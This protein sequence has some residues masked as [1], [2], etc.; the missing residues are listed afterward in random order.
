MKL[1]SRISKYFVAYLAWVLFILLFVVVILLGRDVLLGYLRNIWAQQ[2]L[3]RQYAINFFD[4]GYVLGIGITW[5]ILMIIM[6]SYFRNGVVKNV[7]PHRLSLVFGYLILTIFIIHLLMAIM[8]GI[9]TQS[10]LQWVLLAG[11]FVLSAGLLVISA[12]TPKKSKLEKIA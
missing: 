1:L 4:R 10:S 3:A 12:K 11:E 9:L 7:L 2:N 5:L 6:E 8:G